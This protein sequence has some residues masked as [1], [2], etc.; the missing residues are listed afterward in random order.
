[1]KSNVTNWPVPQFVY[2]K[3]DQ[4]NYYCHRDIVV[5][6]SSYLWKLPPDPFMELLGIL[7]LGLNSLHVIDCRSRV[8]GSNA[9]DPWGWLTM[10]VEAII[11]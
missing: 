10:E 11:G 8:S 2:P 5:K 4:G 7:C 6:D 3:L 1:M 9:R